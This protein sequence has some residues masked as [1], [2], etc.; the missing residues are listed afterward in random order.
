MVT[1]GEV[2][3]LKSHLLF[4][5]FLSV[6]KIKRIEEKPQFDREIHILLL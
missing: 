5:S 4:F 1:V 2:A 3:Y 6:L